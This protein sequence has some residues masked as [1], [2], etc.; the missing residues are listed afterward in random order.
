MFR[1]AGK[2][3]KQQTDPPSIPVSHLFPQGIFPEG[4]RQSYSNEYVS[5]AFKSLMDA[6]MPSLN[7][8]HVILAGHDLITGLMGILLQ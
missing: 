6:V 7:S 8:I 5:L 1:L 4:E 2:G 3:P